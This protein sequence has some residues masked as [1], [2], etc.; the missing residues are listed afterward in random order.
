MKSFSPVARSLAAVAAIAVLAG[1]AACGGYSAISIGGTVLGLT[2]DGLVLANGSNTVA[3]PA[4]ATSYTFPQQIGN[5]ASYSVNIQSQPARLTCT[6]GN[7]VGTAS[8]IDINW[9]NVTCSPNTYAL[10]GTVTN[11]TT[12]GL[13]LTNGSDTVAIAPGAT[14]FTFPTKVADGSV[15]GVAVLTQPAG[16]T[17][18]V[19]NGTATMGSA[20]VT[21]VQ[22]NCI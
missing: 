8:G 11:L 18:T 5:Y 3:V 17:C 21:N 14:S 6:I 15:Y 13:T 2:T 12:T 22:V 16:Q 19:T 20:D 1:L 9:I 4:N 10:G 7:N